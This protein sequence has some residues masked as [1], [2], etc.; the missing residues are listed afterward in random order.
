MRS[1]KMLRPRVGQCDI[2]YREMKIYESNEHHDYD[3]PVQGNTTM[4][5][6]RRMKSM[7]ELLYSIV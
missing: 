3:H 2:W 7:S 4:T 6:L 5:S 1:G